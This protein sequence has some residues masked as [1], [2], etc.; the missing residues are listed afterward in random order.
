[1]KNGGRVFVGQRDETFYI[2]L[3]GTFDT[4]NLHI[5]PILSPVDDANDALLLG[6][7][8]DTFSG[9]NVNTIA[10]EIPIGDLMGPNGNKLIGDLCDDEPS[11]SHGDQEGW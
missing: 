6:A 7:A 11:E 5:S 2:D 1:L 4:L 10:L 3:G 9:F 8:R